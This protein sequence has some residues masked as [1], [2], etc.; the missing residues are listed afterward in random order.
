M[1]L[2]CQKAA[3]AGSAKV[4]LQVGQCAGQAQGGGL[5]PGAPQRKGE[6][7]ACAKHEALRPSWQRPA[8]D[9]QHI[10]RDGI[11]MISRILGPSRAMPSAAP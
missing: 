8:A 10:L 2:S 11:R 3:L 4:H 6:Q 9:G 1:M 5:E 7:E